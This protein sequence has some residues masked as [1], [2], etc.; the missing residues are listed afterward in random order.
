MIR[1]N[2]NMRYILDRIAE[3]FGNNKQIVEYLVAMAIAYKLTLP[4]SPVS[5]ISSYMNLTYRAY[6]DDIVSK[7]N[8]STPIN[9]D[10]VKDMVAS[11]YRFRYAMVFDPYNNLGISIF[12]A[13]MIGENSHLSNQLVAPALGK[14]LSS[15][16]TEENL[17]ELN[18]I[19]S[20]LGEGY[21]V[22]NVVV[23]DGI[24]G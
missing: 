3:S 4:T 23:P 8:E 18:D 20:T 7:I 2:V 15:C 14:F 10:S 1:F 9:V 22:P 21:E 6:I 16:L 13:L 5:S 12:R 24:G 17:R 19:I 11:V